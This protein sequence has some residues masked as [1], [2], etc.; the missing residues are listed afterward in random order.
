MKESIEI[1]K[2]TKTYSHQQDTKKKSF[3]KIEKDLMFHKKG[4]FV[5]DKDLE[6]IRNY[7]KAL[8]L[9]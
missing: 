6:L 1:N 4:M 2:M 3:S 7:L 8:L 5:L 9:I